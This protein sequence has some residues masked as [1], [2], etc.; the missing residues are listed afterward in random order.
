MDGFHLDD[1]ILAA[2]GRRHRKGA[3]DTFDVAGFVALLASLRSGQIVYAPKFDRSLELSRNCAI[4]I[5]TP[6]K[7]VI[8][9][10]NYLLHDTQG[11][12]NVRP[13][14]DVCWYLHVPKA[15]LRARSVDRWKVL[16]FSDTDAT[17]KADGN[18]MRN[19]ALVH[20][21][22]HRADRVLSLADMPEP[23]RR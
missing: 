11:W 4:Q 17:Q 8:V 3:P 13:L 1:N 23:D 15:T 19:A 21:G 5:P 16:G 7:L 10:G 20:E 14:L 12:Q 9:E 22:R 2:Q 18:D 6:A